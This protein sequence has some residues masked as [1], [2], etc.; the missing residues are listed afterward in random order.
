MTWRRYAL[1]AGAA[2]SQGLTMGPLVAAALGVHPAM[3]LTAFL[4]TSAVFACFSGAALLSR[5]RSW[6]YLSGALSSALSVFLIM[7]LG[8]W[9]FG[10]R[11]LA[12]Q[13]ELYGGLLVF[14]GYILLDTQVLQLRPVSA[15]RC[16]L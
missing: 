3:L 5:R 4:T 2:Y 13:A 11:A 9:M 12:F 16:I 15:F 7:R 1:L 14:V 6:L 8:V 10:G